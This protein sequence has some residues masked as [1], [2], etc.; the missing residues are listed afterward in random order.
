MIQTDP[1]RRCAFALVEAMIMVISLGAGMALG[2]A[3]L[4]LALQTERAAD[5]THHTLVQRR[6]L[7][8]QF[9][10]DVSRATTTRERTYLGEDE[11]NA[12][13]TCLIL[14]GPGKQQVVYL[15]LSGH[16]ERIQLKGG[17]ATWQSLP[18]GARVAGMELS[19]VSGRESLITLRL[20]E[21][22]RK[23]GAERHFDLSAALGGDWR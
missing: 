7:A 13:P 6:A 1:Q 10:A 16:L 19:H 14:E 15:W 5:Q 3:T 4:I 22:T 17:Q 8:E 23:G 20:K 12:S 21:T 11:V 18:V 2:G 9:R